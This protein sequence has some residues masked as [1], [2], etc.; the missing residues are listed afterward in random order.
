MPSLYDGLFRKANETAT[1]LSVLF[2]LTYRCNTLCEHCY[3]FWKGREIPKDELTLAEIDRILAET[4]EEGALFVTFTGGEVL[5]RRDF[6]DVL[7]AAREKNF[8][9]RIYT[10]GTLVDESR[11]DRIASFDPME[12]ELS[13]Y[14]ADAATHDAV[15]G[16]PGSFAKVVRAARALVERGVRVNLKTTLM[17]RNIEQAGG[18]RALAEGLGATYYDSDLVTPRDDGDLR[19]TALR[20]ADDLLRAHYAPHGAS[21]RE[22]G[23]LT[24]RPEDYHCGTGKNSC[25]IGPYGDVFPC[26]QIRESA[27]NLRTRSFREIWRGSKS[28]EALRALRVRDFPICSRCPLLAYCHWCPGVSLLEHGD[29][30]APSIEAC[31]AAKIV[32]EAALGRPV[33]NPSP[34]EDL[35]RKDPEGF[36]T[37][38]GGGSPSAKSCGSCSAG[39]CAQREQT[40]EGRDL[41]P[42]EGLRGKAGGGKAA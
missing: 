33:A 28:L 40:G 38:A 10:N 42:L 13:L 15:S 12:V 5:L 6:F 25:T 29:A 21:L 3:V 39:G 19:T 41:V 26:V 31:R 20:P 2:E 18:M 22:E 17:K 35:L 14:G 9:V 8:A 34:L 1:P 32:A 11:A 23:R 27:G 37:L 36:R 24:P 4:A 16:C 30:L 7:S